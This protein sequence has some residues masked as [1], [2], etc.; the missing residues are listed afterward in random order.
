MTTVKLLV[1]CMAFETSRYVPGRRWLGFLRLLSIP[2]RFKH[3]KRHLI[4]PMREPGREQKEQLVS[5]SPNFNFLKISSLLT[6]SMK[7]K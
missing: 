3:S 1:S 4:A 7:S 6:K 5:A 2:W